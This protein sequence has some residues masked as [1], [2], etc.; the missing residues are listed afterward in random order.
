MEILD[1]D[2]RCATG[3]GAGPRNFG[4]PRDDGLCRF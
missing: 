4:I 1:D 3:F 2:I